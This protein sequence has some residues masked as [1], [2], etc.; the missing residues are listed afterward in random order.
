M[1]SPTESTAALWLIWLNI[2]MWQPQSSLYLVWIYRLTCLQQ[3]VA[4][5]VFIWS[6]FARINSDAL[7]SDLFFL[8]RLSSTRALARLPCQQAVLDKLGQWHYQQVQSGWQRHGGAGDS[9]EGLSQRHS[10][11]RDGWVD[12]RDRRWGLARERGGITRLTS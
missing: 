4:V 3:I 11:S 12:L 10:S 7:S 6:F 5:L 9:E 8:P 2:L 1:I